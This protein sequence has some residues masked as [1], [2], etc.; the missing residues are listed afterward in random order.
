MAYAYYVPLTEERRVSFGF[1]GRLQQIGFDRARLQA[2][3]GGLDPVALNQNNCLKGDAGFGA[4]Y[5]SPTL[6]VG[7]SVS[8]LVQ[9]KYK[10]YEVYGTSL[11]QSRLYRHFYLHGAYTWRSD[12]ATQIIPNA[13]FTYLPN[14]P[15]E[16]QTGVRV[17]HNELLWY[18]LGWRARQGWMISAGMKLK[19]KFSIGYSFDIYRSPLSVYEKGSPGH[20]LLLHYEWR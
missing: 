13:L 15:V 3:L 8:Q 10:L 9:S 19:Q 16:V 12:D 18:G 6:Q 4:A 2:G 1:E 14:A 17:I 5:T 20:E 11:E 7:A